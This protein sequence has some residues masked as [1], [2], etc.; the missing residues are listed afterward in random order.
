MNQD[1]QSKK[2][3]LYPVQNNKNSTETEPQHEY[4]EYCHDRREID[5]VHD[6]EDHLSHHRN[7]IDLRA[8]FPLAHRVVYAR[9]WRFIVLF[10]CTTLVSLFS[11]LYVPLDAAPGAP[12]ITIAV[13]HY[14]HYAFYAALLLLSIKLIY[15]ELYHMTFYYAI[16][17]EHFVISTG[18]LLK[19]R[20]SLHISDLTDVFL[21]RSTVDLI[22]L[23]YSIRVANPSPEKPEN[24]YIH[25]LS[26]ADAIA[27]QD[28]L[29]EL[30]KR[31][32]EGPAL[33]EQIQRNEKEDESE[34][35]VA[36]V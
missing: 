33:V 3:I 10:L 32:K 21:E 20:S 28:F 36:S 17:A 35:K 7:I 22:F 5:I 14:S 8:T 6:P 11:T 34:I 30:I 27:L 4:N 12:A 13:R 19:S 18:V 24:E 23:I 25:G 15:E 1:S 2:R 16:E 9:S 26:S 29:T 31:T